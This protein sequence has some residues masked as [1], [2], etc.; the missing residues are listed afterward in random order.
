MEE[1]ND[2]TNNN[3]LIELYQFVPVISSL[4]ISL[5][6]DMY[7]RNYLSRNLILEIE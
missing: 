1:E 2:F 5:K 6:N 3:N 4:L 7:D